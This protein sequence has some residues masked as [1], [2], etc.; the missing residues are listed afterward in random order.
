MRRRD[1]QP[2]ATGKGCGWL[3]LV[4]AVLLLAVMIISF[5]GWLLYTKGD[6]GP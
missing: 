3:T 1:A 5:L 2:Q 4:V 6:A